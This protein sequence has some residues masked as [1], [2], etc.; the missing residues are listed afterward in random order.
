MFTTVVRAPPSQLWRACIPYFLVDAT[1]LLFDRVSIYDVIQSQQQKLKEKIQSLDSD[2][3][4]NASEQDL[5]SWL[6]D[7]FKMEVPSL[8]E[9]NIEMAHREKQFDVSRGALRIMYGDSTSIQGTEV[10]FIVRFSGDA[11]FFEVMPQRSIRNI[12][13]AGEVTFGNGEIRFTYASPNLN[14]AQAKRE[15]ENELQNIKQNLQN[16]RASVSQRNSLLE[17]EIRQQVTQRKQKLLNDAQMAAALGYRI[18]K[19][20]GAP[21][22]YAV[23]VQKRVPKI[24]APPVATSSFK[25]EPVLA[26]EEYDN[27][28]E[29]IRSMVH[30]M[31][32]SPKA[33][34]HMEEEDLRTHFLVQLN[35]QYEGKAS[36]ETFNFQGKTDILIRDGDRNV[37]IAECKFW[38]GEKKFLETIDQLLSY[39]SWRD[40]KAAVIIFNRKAKFSDVVK[41]IEEIAPKHKCYKRRTG[42]SG[43][44]SFRFVFHQP[45][46]PNREIILTIMAFDVPTAE[47]RSK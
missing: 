19:R 31:E 35:A 32:R 24:T 25:P 28:L 37:F 14:G 9:A 33:F 38:E 8:D 11:S 43:E 45:N 20:D 30:V 46:D 22:T 39:L 4:L 7:E 13:G 5:I 40:T 47:H 16:L 17:Q 18:R 1:M 29:I 36:G 26:M 10:T 34:E 27:I 21:T 3:L 41:K 6:V 44:S 12:S 23:P 2:Y 15:F 42:N